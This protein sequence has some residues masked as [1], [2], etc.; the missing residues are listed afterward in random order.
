MSGPRRK[1]RESGF[2]ILLVFVLAAVI[3]IS[4]YYELPRVMFEHTREREQLL[5]DRGEQYSLAVRRFY[6]KFGRWP[7]KMDD[8]EN[9]NNIR[10]LRRQ[11]KDPMTGEGDW[12]IIHETAGVLTDSLVHP[13]NPLAQGQSGSTGGT[14]QTFGSLTSSTP[15]GSSLAASSDSSSD[16]PAP[17]AWGM[18]ARPSDRGALGTAHGGVSTGNDLQEPAAYPDMANPNPPPTNAS[19]QPPSTQAPTAP[20]PNAP[21]NQSGTGG[22]G[23][24]TAGATGPNE[25]ILAIQRGLY[26]PRQLPGAASGQQSTAVTGGGIGIAG[27]ASKSNMRGIK[28]YNDHRKYKEWEFVFDMSKLQQLQNPGQNATP[29]QNSPLQG[30]QPPPTTGGA[31]NTGTNP[32]Q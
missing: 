12:R 8:L 20:D 14:G 25:A 16:Q 1:P 32:T 15:T 3:A 10:F 18:E 31:N 6:V 21:A 26:G 17:D 28:S 11:Y 22:G 13:A 23:A 30:S 5:I 7:A 27:V 24:G 9:T 29:A 2:A 4:L 19:N